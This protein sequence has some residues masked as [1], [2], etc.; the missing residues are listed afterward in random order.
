[1]KRRAKNRSPV[2]GDHLQQAERGRRQAPQPHLQ[3]LEDRCIATEDGRPGHREG[4][5]ELADEERTAT[6][7]AGDDV[8]PE[9]VRGTR[10]CTNGLRRIRPIRGDEKERRRLDE[11]PS[12]RSAFRL[13]ERT[14]LVLFIDDL[15]WRRMRVAV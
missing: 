8:P 15:Q 13:A 2:N 3:N 12:P 11:V 4:A 1:M 5:N 6:G 7:L 10:E 9:P 14:K